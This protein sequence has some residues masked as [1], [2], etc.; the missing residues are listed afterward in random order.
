MTQDAEIIKFNLEKYP[1]IKRFLGNIIDQ[2]LGIEC[3]THGMLTANLLVNN[4]PDL[5]KLDKVL[6]L[7]GKYCIDFKRIFQ[8]KG[9]SEQSEIADGQIIDMLAEVK[10]FEFLHAQ[11][12]TEI[13]N[14]KREQVK[15]V[16]FIAIRDSHKYAVEATRLGLAQSKEKQPIYSFQASTLSYAKCEDADGFEFEWI[17][18]GINVDRLIKEISDAIYGKLG[19]IRGFCQRESDISKAILVISSGRDYFV[20]RKYENKAYEITPTQDFLKAL[21]TIWHSLRQEGLDDCLHH[22]VITRGKDLGK[23]IIRP[24]FDA[25]EQT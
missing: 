8:S 7:G 9:L 15:T 24:P 18:G 11:K 1:S 3:Y 23:A 4:E 19:Q 14:V 21:E 17:N 5:D 2:R 6:Q 25:E 10:T 12:F 22:L 20:M 16:D 13:V